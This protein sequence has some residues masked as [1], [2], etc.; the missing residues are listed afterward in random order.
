MKFYNGKTLNIAI[1]SAGAGPAVSIIKSLKKQ[2]FLK[3]N[4]FAYAS[5]ISSAGLYLADKYRLVPK[6][7]DPDYLKKV[8][9]FMVTDNIDFAFPILD[10]EVM[11]F[12]K[13]CNLISMKTNTKFFLNNYNSVKTC[14]NKYD[15]FVFNKSIN[16][17]TPN[18]FKYNELNY[19]K[20]KY[21]ILMKPIIGV[22]SRGQY[23]FDRFNDIGNEFNDESN[24][25]C[26]YIEG[27]E[28][29]I[30]ALALF[31]D[32]FLIVPR[33]RI[34]VRMGQ[35]VKGETVYDENLISIAKDILK[36]YSINDVACLQV[37]KKNNDYY[38]I[39][40]NPR[41]G[42]GISLS[43]ESGPIFP[44]LQIFKALGIDFPKNF[45]TFKSGLKV[46]RYW[47][48]VFYE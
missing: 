37:I 42:T 10:S 16:I 40:L 5:D 2:T 11:I 14:L 24:L 32:D 38:F 25:F 1:F 13:N 41:Y 29:S 33:R 34:E 43:I 36:K 48:E 27:E 15:S 8:V 35:M 21:K 31:N 3:I 12:S 17:L 4:I 22:G 45:L 46:S 26:E 9:N 19:I 30:D 47:E 20:P 44:V 28:Y 6:I 18:H 23:L 39:E 7:T